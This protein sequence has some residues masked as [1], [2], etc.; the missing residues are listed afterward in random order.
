MP[1]Y[2]QRSCMPGSRAQIYS[3][4]MRYASRCY[5]IWYDQR[6]REKKREDFYRAEGG[7]GER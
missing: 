4:A 5:V 2:P 7:G 6:V 3:H 1:P